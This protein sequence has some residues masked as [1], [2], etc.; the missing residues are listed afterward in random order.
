MAVSLKDAYFARLDAACAAHNCDGRILIQGVGRDEDEEE[1]EEEE[2]VRS[3]LPACI[4]KTPCA[5]R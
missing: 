4:K 3:T 1:E 5:V 2:E